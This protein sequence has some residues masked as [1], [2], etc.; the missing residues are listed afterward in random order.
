MSISHP[1]RSP[2]LFNCITC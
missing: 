2:V 1:I